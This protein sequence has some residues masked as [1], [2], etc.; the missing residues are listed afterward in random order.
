MKEKELEEIPKQDKLFVQKYKANKAS[1][2]INAKTYFNQK[3]LD[4]S[5]IKLKFKTANTALKNTA[6]ID[7]H[8]E[9]L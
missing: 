9:T 6:T 4:F 3:T 2:I 8:K 1:K 5:C 7:N